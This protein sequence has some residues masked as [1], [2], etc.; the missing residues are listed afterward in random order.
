MAYGSIN[1]RNRRR[2]G[3]GG[4]QAPGGAQSFTPREE[5]YHGWPGG[6]NPNTIG[7][8]TGVT[9]GA[10]T[11]IDEPWAY[12]GFVD[13][14]GGGPWNDFEYFSSIN[15]LSDLYEAWF[16]QEA[17]FGLNPTYWYGD[18]SPE[19]GASFTDWLNWQNET[20]W[21]NA[22][23][24]YL[25]YEWGG[26]YS[27]TQGGQGDL[28]TGSG[29][30]GGGV[31][32]TQQYGGI[33]EWDCASWGPSYNAQGECIACCGDEWD[34]DY[35]GPTEWSLDPDAGSGMMGPS[36]PECHSQWMATQDSGYEGTYSEFASVY[37]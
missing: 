25:D 34:P 27:G 24:N 15:T 10:G 14:F 23:P 13:Y 26:G 4:F 11:E 3:G 17:G 2:P 16:N 5:E 1:N 18:Y 36:D 30:Q 8:D 9:F 35:E 28:G 12:P 7:P 37:C 6:T 20:G 31:W 29:F 32:A 33:T 22:G 19:S 21:F